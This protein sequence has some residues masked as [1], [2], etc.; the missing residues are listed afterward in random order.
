[1]FNF[2]LPVPLS[3][4][5]FFCFIILKTW[6]KLSVPQYLSVCPPVYFVYL[7]QSTSCVTSSDPLLFLAAILNLKVYF[8]PLYLFIIFQPNTSLITTALH[9][10]AHSSHWHSTVYHF[11]YV[12]CIIACVCILK[13]IFC[14]PNFP[15]HSFFVTVF[16]IFRIIY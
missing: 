8:I 4:V 12:I 13:H 3:A 1:M 5:I 7:H 11:P 9:N 6:L 2:L 14:L 10:T 16:D 15:L